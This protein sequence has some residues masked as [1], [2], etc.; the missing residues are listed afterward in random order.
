MELPINCGGFSLFE[1]GELALFKPDPEPQKH[2]VIQIWQTPYT[3]QLQPAVEQKDSLLFKIGNPDIVGAMAECQEVLTLLGKDDSYADLYVDIARKS[4]DILDSWFWLG[5]EAARLG[6]PPRQGALVG[7]VQPNS[8]ADRAGLR[9]GDAIAAVNGK[10]VRSFRDVNALSRDFLQPGKPVALTLSDGRTV[11]LVPERESFRDEVTGEPA[12]RLA[13]GFQPY[14]RDP[15]DGHALL[16]SQ[17]PLARGAGEIATLAWRQLHEVVRLTVL[18]IARIVTGDISFKTV[19][20]PIMLFSIAS[21]A[22]EEGWGSFLFKMALISVNLGLMNLLP[23][24]VLDGGHIAACAVEAV[25]RRRISVRARAAAFSFYPGKNLGAY[26]DGGAVTTND[27]NVADTIRMLRNYGQREKYHHLLQGFNR[28]LDTMQAAILR[29]KL[30]HLDEW[31]A[32][33]REHAAG[34]QPLGQVLLERLAGDVE[35][36]LGEH[37][38]AG[39]DQRLDRVHAALLDAQAERA[40]LRVDDGRQGVD[41]PVEVVDAVAHAAEQAVAQQVVHLVD[42]ELARESLRS[43]HIFDGAKFGIASLA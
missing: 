27:A 38:V 14:R 1:N 12:E 33:R 16:A 7:S 11:S 18:G 32:A 37:V 41:Q 34:A 8:P 23:I 26:G 39:E 19:G 4:G 2:H 36:D 5:E 22:A 30:K 20:G 13:L 3:A 25:T 43:E 35:V 15:V 9:R 21:E 24:P 10:P 6:V 31:N 40:G 29:V 42:V 28:R 17:V